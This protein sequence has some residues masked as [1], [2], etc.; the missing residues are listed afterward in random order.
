MCSKMVQLQQRTNVIVMQGILG[1]LLDPFF[2]VQ[3]YFELVPA[4][5]DEPAFGYLVDGVYMP[6]TYATAVCHEGNAGQGRYDPSRFAGHSLCRGGVT[7]AYQCGVNPLLI[8][9]QGIDFQ[10]LGCC[11]LG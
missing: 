1:H 9:I 11:I 3:W 6:L 5:A 8:R 7:F 10:M 2:W 4:Q